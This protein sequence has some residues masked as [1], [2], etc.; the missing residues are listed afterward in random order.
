MAEINIVDSPMGS[1]KTTAIIN[2]INS[3][4][5]RKYIYIAPFL[6]EGERIKSH[7]SSLNFCA[8]SELFSKTADL[9]NL[10]SDGKNIVSTHALFKL[11]DNSTID[12]LKSQD[13]VLIMDEVI[14]IVDIVNITDKDR[15]LLFDSNLLSVDSNNKLQ[16]NDHSYTGNF[17]KM[18]Q[19]TETDKLFL[20][21]EK[22]IICQFPV[23]AFEGF[24]D[25]YILT[26]L[27]SGSKLKSYFDT[28]HLKYNYFYIDDSMNIQKGIFD[29]RPFKERIKPLINLYEGKLNDIGKKT[30]AL[31]VNW[32]K[33]SNKEEHEKLRKGVYNY[34]RH[35][36]DTPSQLNM[37]SVFSKYEDK[38]KGGGYTSGF[39]ACNS[40]ATNDYR[41]KKS[42]AYLVNIYENPIIVHWFNYRGASINEDD[43]ALSQ[44]L[45]WIWRSRIRD[46]REI[47]L[48]IPSSRMRNLFT[49]W[50]YS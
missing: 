47:N 18:K 50:L 39:V 38:Y 35:K 42:L 21:D 10:I 43:F 4:P 14:D 19:M 34:F 29:D 16:W 46:G 26:Y 25:V 8:P 33:S 7:C 12:L 41:D 24:K 32:F 13:Y 1:G 22:I 2:Y 30:T 9:K 36:V 23:E 5:T 11:I 44:L 27:F 20:F 31:S 48:Y 49:E 45:Q 15:K 37:W 3:N 17:N 28:Y 40:R 6:S